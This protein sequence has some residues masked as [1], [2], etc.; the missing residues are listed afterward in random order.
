MYCAIL[1][2]IVTLEFNLS[3]FIRCPELQYSVLELI[4]QDNFGEM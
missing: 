3:F 2:Q 1:I 4:N